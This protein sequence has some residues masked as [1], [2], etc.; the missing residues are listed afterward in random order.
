MFLCYLEVGDDLLTEAFLQTISIVE[1]S[2]VSKAL[3]VSS[4]TFGNDQRGRLAAIL[5][6]FGSRQLPAPD[7]LRQQIIQASRFEYLIKPGPAQFS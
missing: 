3:H 6:R 4:A 5:S 2:Q 7:R 1:A